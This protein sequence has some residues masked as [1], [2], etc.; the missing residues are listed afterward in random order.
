MSEFFFCCGFFLIYFIEE[1]VHAAFAPESPEAEL[2]SALKRLG[3]ITA[4]M[5]CVGKT[6]T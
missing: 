6:S 4:S 5:R 3:S 1:L 2:R